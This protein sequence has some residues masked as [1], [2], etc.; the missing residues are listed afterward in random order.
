MTTP[1]YSG[2]G[3]A[4]YRYDVAG[5]GRKP[6]GECPGNV[7][8][9]LGGGFLYEA[10][11]WFGVTVQRTPVGP[12]GWPAGT[13][14]RVKLAD[15]AWQTA[16]VSLAVGEHGLFVCEAGPG[17][18]GRTYHLDPLS[19]AVRGRPILGR[20]DETHTVAAAFPDRSP[21]PPVAFG[22]GDNWV[23]VW[24]EGLRFTAQEQSNICQAVAQQCEAW[25]VPVVV[26]NG[27]PPVSKDRIYLPGEYGTVRVVPQE[28][29]MYPGAAGWAVSKS[30]TSYGL[31]PNPGRE[32][33]RPCWVCEASVDQVVRCILHEGIGHSLGGLPDRHTIGL[34]G[35]GPGE[36]GMLMSV[37]AFDSWQRNVGLDKN[38]LAAI[39]AMWN[40]MVGPGR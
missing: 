26:S 6:F 18:T 32:L 20:M 8:V 12:D 39:K 17:M 22:S 38:E 7:A 9:A 36:P 1:V 27:R 16:R 37:A 13:P 40:G 5:P 15:T 14:H 33:E 31:S 4:V 34:P 28:R 35:G 29:W 3:N 11:S 21:A 30:W 24:F 23:V 25:G 19:L 10:T 2:Q